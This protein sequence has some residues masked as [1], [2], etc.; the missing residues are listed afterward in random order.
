MKDF[1]F[2]KPWSDS[3]IVK[4][5]FKS[6]TGEAHAD[7]A[8]W[9]NVYQFINGMGINTDSTLQ[10]R[11]WLTRAMKAA[12]TILATQYAINPIPTFINKPL[13]LDKNGCKADGSWKLATVTLPKP[14]LKQQIAFIVAEYMF[15][16]PFNLANTRVTEGA[17]A[18]PSINFEELEFLG[19]NNITPLLKF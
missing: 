17:S 11:L 16:R 19:I 1:E 4:G 7:V 9:L 15:V 3:S 10:G 13:I 2:W 12:K 18:K 5:T 6:A 14:T 8:D